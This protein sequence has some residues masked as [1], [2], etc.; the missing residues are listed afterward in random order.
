M[1]ATTPFADPL[2]VAALRDLVVLHCARSHHC[3][4]VHFGAFARTRTGVVGKLITN[5]PEQLRREAL[6]E[7][8]LHLSGP[9]SPGAFAERLVERSSAV[10]DH[11]SGRLFRTGIEDSF[12]KMRALTST[13][14][15]EVIM[16][17]AGRFLRTAAPVRQP[18]RHRQQIPHPRP[19]GITQVRAVP[20][21]AFRPVGRVP[22][23]MGETVTPRSARTG[24]GNHD[25]ATLRQQGPCFSLDSTTASCQEALPSCPTAG[26][27]TRSRTPF[28]ADRAHERIEQ[29]QLD[30]VE[31]CGCVGEAEPKHWLPMCQALPCARGF[32]CAL[33]PRTP[34]VGFP[35]G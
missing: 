34:C 16:P 28:E 6:R 33:P 23:P 13:W 3:R 10:R 22:E 21:T 35:R 19:L 17:E 7:T 8:G 18:S 27:L 5:F 14:Q 9:A 29:G 11:E 4:D 32:S 15:L 1:H 31:P 20:G 25:H 26:Q 30:V 12:H 2:H 24:P